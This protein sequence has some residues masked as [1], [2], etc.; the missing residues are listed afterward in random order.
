VKILKSKDSSLWYTKHIGKTV[1]LEREDDLYYWSR[2]NGGYINI[3]HKSDAEIV[4]NY[5]I[6][7]NI[8]L[9]YD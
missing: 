8:V 5:E 9:G 2:D 1:I 4:N 3:I 7:N 6:H